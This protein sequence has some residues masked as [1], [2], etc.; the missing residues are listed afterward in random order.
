MIMK[1]VPSHKE[2]AD[3]EI[4]V[5]FFVRMIS[6]Y[7]RYPLAW[8]HGNEGLFP[9]LSILAKQHIVVVSQA[10]GIRRPNM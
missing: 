1:T 3:K 9:L 4:S 8:L 6:T 10:G 7:R 5:Y 2:A